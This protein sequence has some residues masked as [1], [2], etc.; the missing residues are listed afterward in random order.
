MQTREE[1]ENLGF[2]RINSKKGVLLPPCVS[3]PPL[4]EELVAAIAALPVAGEGDCCCHRKPVLL[5]RNVTKEKNPFAVFSGLPPL[6]VLPEI[7]QEDEE[8]I[9]F[10]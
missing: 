6:F 9:L 7:E 4:P 2:C 5:H 10:G 1:A 3:P 8:P